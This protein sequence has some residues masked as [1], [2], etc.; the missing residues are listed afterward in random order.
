MTLIA[1]FIGYQFLHTASV[2]QNGLGG[3]SSPATTPVAVATA[4]IQVKNPYDMG[5]GQSSDAAPA[6]STEKEQA[7]PVTEPGAP[8]GATQPPKV[9]EPQGPV[10]QSTQTAISAQPAVPTI[11]IPSPTAPTVNAAQGQDNDKRFNDSDKRMTDIETRM[12]SL[13][14]KLNAIG[15]ALM[16]KQQSESAKAQ[17]QPATAKPKAEPP[18]VVKK[19]TPE[20]LSEAGKNFIV[21]GLITNQAWLEN[22]ATGAIEIVSVG[23]VLSDGSKVSKIDLPSNT[24]STSRGAI[25]GEQ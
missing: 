22:R 11:T 14:K 15:D 2:S 23:S 21:L 1:G 16:R 25:V 4:P 17:A 24:V 13:D 6:T 5:S 20:K 10:N 3:L 7:A 12:A 19:P 8:Q 9:P 18:K